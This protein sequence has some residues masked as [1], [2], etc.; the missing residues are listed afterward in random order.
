MPAP[1]IAAGGA[2]RGADNSSTRAPLST[3]DRIR[4]IIREFDKRFLLHEPHSGALYYHRDALPYAR[5]LQKKLAEATNLLGPS[6]QKQS[7]AMHAAISQSQRQPQQPLQERATDSELDAAEFKEADEQQGG[8]ESAVLARHFWGVD[9]SHRRAAFQAAGGG[10]GGAH[11]RIEER[12]AAE[13]VLRRSH[14]F[15]RYYISMH[16]RHPFLKEKGIR[17]HPILD[18]RQGALASAART[19]GAAASAAGHAPDPQLAYS[20]RKHFAHR[21]ESTTDRFGGR[22]LSERTKALMRELERMQR[23]EQAQNEGKNKQQ[24]RRKRTP[25]TPKKR[26]E[27]QLAQ[28]KPADA[29]PSPPSLVASA[30]AQSAQLSAPGAASAG[31]L[32]QPPD[33]VAAQ[34]SRIESSLAQVSQA[35]AGGSGSSGGSSLGVNGGLQR[36]ESELVQM[37]LDGRRKFV[38]MLRKLKDLSDGSE[39][40]DRRLE[41]LEHARE[42]I[43]EQIETGAAQQQQQPSRKTA[44]AW[45]EAGQMAPQRPAGAAPSALDRTRTPQQQQQQPQLRGNELTIDA[46]KLASMQL[47]ES[48]FVKA[49]A[50]LESERTALRD[51]R[52]ALA[53]ARSEAAE[54]VAK[55]GELASLVAAHGAAQDKSKFALLEQVAELNNLNSDLRAKRERERALLDGY[56]AELNRYKR[57]YADTERD[58]AAERERASRVEAEKKRLTERL[59]A[60]S[61]QLVAAEERRVTVAVRETLSQRTNEERLDKLKT[62]VL[63][64]MFRHYR[65]QYTA[66]LAHADSHD[67]RVRALQ[68]KIDSLKRMHAQEKALAEARL[69]S[70]AE[71]TGGV[72]AAHKN[73]SQEMA[74]KYVE[75][76]ER[77]ETL[78]KQAAEREAALV[79]AEK[80]SNE[81]ATRIAAEGGIIVRASQP[82]AHVSCPSFARSVLIFSV[83]SLCRRKTKTSFPS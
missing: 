77:V 6:Q 11:D 30:V 5:M 29:K 46:D 56:E 37:R 35:L 33:A 67:F 60:L 83:A 48:E 81:L 22:V 73:L 69:K 32:A 42:E 47:A 65:A 40:T 3:L 25:V 66:L 58:L 76:I 34:L 68:T 9:A 63:R 41:A 38:V 10:G 21:A 2:A 70:E 74:R 4:L 36:L 28:R 16:D 14:G 45:T 1:S 44:N 39:R 15:A 50:E 51:A 23:A 53:A 71:Q 20:L 75:M 24:Q 79:A 19:S 55:N 49:R 52:A 62:L 80:K 57:A 54:L 31:I 7:S 18:S 13:S 12:A 59:E 78:E 82:R 72:L 43:P 64:A 17:S 8:D 27:H 26:T 61:S